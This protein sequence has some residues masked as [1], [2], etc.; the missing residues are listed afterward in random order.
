ME[1]DRLKETKRG[2][3]L[4]GEDGEGNGVKSF[5][6]DG[7]KNMKAGNLVKLRKMLGGRNSRGL[8]MGGSTEISRDF[9]LRA[10]QSFPETLCSPC[11]TETHTFQLH[12][13]DNRTMRRWLCLSTS[14]DTKEI[15]S[16]PHKMLVCHLKSAKLRLK[17]NNRLIF[18]FLWFSPVSCVISHFM[19]RLLAASVSC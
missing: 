3:G 18:R 15:Q 19:T 16:K 7:D 17:D 5:A 9:W 1:V 13:N 4:K 11:R 12:S 2:G 8:G 6:G 10:T 14:E